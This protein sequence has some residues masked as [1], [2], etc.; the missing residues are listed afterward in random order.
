MDLDQLQKDED[1]EAKLEQ[2]KL[3]VKA[4]E[5]EELLRKGRPGKGHQR[6]YKRFCRFC[7]TEYMI[8]IENC[9]NC[10]KETMTED[11]G[12]F[13]NVLTLIRNATMSS[14]AS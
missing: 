7:F 1:E 11:V 12:L 5:R 2:S 10:G 3:D 9:T 4:R 14:R 6:G 13:R 8:D